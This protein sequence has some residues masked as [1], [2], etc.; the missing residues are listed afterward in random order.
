MVTHLIER[1]GFGWAMRI[2]AFLILFLLTIANLTVKSRIAPQP[3]TVSLLD[4][5]KPF[6]EVTYLLS[7]V[8]NFLFTFA[9]FM[10]ISYIVV[11]ATL[12]GMGTQLA[13]YLV[14]IL[15]AAR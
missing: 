7:V 2:C 12:S 10:P 8:G 6:T 5:L 13:Q 4:F 9:F 3:R 15:N 11:E 1:I 14:A